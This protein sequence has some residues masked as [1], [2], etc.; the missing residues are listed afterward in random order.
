MTG[1]GAKSVLPWTWASGSDSLKDLRAWRAGQTRCDVPK[2]KSS[3]G[4][5]TKTDRMPLTG[6]RGMPERELLEFLFSSGRPVPAS[7]FR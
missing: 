7:R 5:R 2:T 4:A 3:D 1:F 6:T